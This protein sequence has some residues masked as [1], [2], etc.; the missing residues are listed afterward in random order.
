LNKAKRTFIAALGG[1]VIIAIC[2]FTPILVITL[3]FLGLGMM[4]PYLDF[5]LFPALGILI[6]ISIVS[7]VTW[8]KEMMAE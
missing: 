1:T 5:F 7:F 8:K 3:G 6:I 2:C 4:V